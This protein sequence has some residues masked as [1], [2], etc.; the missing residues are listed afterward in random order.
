MSLSW[1]GLAWEGNIGSNKKKVPFNR[2]YI[3]LTI[4]INRNSPDT[5]HFASLGDDRLLVVT[6][7]AF[8][9]LEKILVCERLA[10]VVFFLIV[11][12]TLPIEV[13][14]IAVQC[15]VSRTVN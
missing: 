12:D 1:S 10:G 8:L 14:L 11:V 7:A 2:F 4:E 5:C 15:R 9:T 3:N 13:L 6:G